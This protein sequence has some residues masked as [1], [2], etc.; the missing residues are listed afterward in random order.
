MKYLA[1][2]ALA[3]LGTVGCHSDRSYS[4][5]PSALVRDANHDNGN[6]FFFWLPPLVNQQTPAEQVL[7]QQLRSTV[8]ITNLCGGAVI[9]TFSGSQVEIADGQYHVNWHTS[10]DNLDPTC[11]YRIAVTAGPRQ[12]GVA[13]VDVVDNGS[14][15][16]NVDT[17]EFI[18]LLDD[19]TLPIKFFIGVGSQC[20]RVDSDCG[21]GTAQPGANTT[22]VTKHGQAGVFIPAGAVDQAVTIIIESSD[23]RP[24]IAGLLEPVFPGSIG[25]IGNACYDF[26]TE[27]PLAEVNASGKFNTNVT[28]GICAEVGNLDHA[29]QELLQIFQRHIGAEPAIFALNNVAAPFLSCDPAYTVPVGSRRSLWGEL[30]ARLRS[31]VV[32][33]P[34]FASTTMALDVGTGGSTDMFSRFTWALPSQL[35][36]NFDQAP[37]LAAIAPGAALNSVYA[38]LGIT[39]SR[40]NTLGACPGTGIYA[41]NVGALGLVTG[42]NNISTCPLGIPADF[43]ALGAGA[44]RASFAV[45]A[46]QACIT[47]TPTGFHVPFMPGGVAFIEALDDAGNVLSR[48]ESSTQRVPQQLCVQAVGIKAVRFAGKGAAFAVFDNL[49]WAR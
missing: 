38:R 35:D 31:L 12:L 23:E 2:V 1:I 44:I 8:T 15:L 47:A 29:T 33:Q 27:P 46:A 7:S 26:H 10:D 13:D 49:R 39:F 37:D 36:L 43:S 30:A 18:P 24:C 41:N 28:V 21:E 25:P 19:R 5:G 14:E 40:T 42:Q 3:A 17:D 20:E 11:T 9:R 34:L 4:A 6:A 45:P 32:P 48:T 22:I 16:K